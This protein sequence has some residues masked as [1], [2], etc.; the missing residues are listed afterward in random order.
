MI[1]AF[2][3]MASCFMHTV[4]ADD[5]SLPP[6][7][8]LV[9]ESIKQMPPRGGYA[10]S[11]AANRALAQAV[12]TR[13]GKLSVDPSRAT[14]SYCSGATYLVFLK[15]LATLQSRGQLN[16]TPG[17][18]SALKPSGQPD[19]TGIWGRWN[20]NGPGTAVLFHEL[21]LGSNFTDLGK[22]RTG[23]FLKIFWNDGIGSTEHGHSVIYL[24][25]ES[26]E[27]VDHLR[28]WSSNIPGGYGEKSV[29]RSK[30]RRMLFSRLEHPG[31]ID[32]PLASHKHSYLSSLERNSSSVSEMKSQCGLG[33]ESPR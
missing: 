4:R 31:N 17:T 10:P 19:G 23:D 21:G 13:D 28:F 33:A 3:G 14:P 26:K 8:R 22:A 7:N 20:A 6:F 32:R 15:T 24:G 30:I 9:I 27:G 2:A 25:T 18:V 29:P 11:V 1:L 5:N 12:D 16:M